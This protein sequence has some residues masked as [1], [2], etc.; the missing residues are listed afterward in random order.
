M[1]DLVQ[2]ENVTARLVARDWAW[3][4]ANRDRIAANWCRRLAATPA[5]FNGRVLMISRL[6]VDADR[7]AVDFFA[8]DYATLL[9]H[10]DFGFEDASVHNGF[11]MGALS[12]RDG[13]F[14]LAEMS[15]GTANAGRLYFAAGTPDRSDVR[16]DDSVD[17]A[18]SILREIGEET[19]LTLGSE[20]LAPGWVVVRHEGRI[21]FMRSVRLAEPADDAR[22]RILAHIAADPKAE[23]ADVVVLRSIA[24]IERESPR[25]PTFLPTYLRWALTEGAAQR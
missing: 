2:V 22:A 23:L 11:A 12:G 25:M 6:Q 1:I 17:L 14:L 3:E 13:G 18:G 7:A 5:L 19:G 16:D 24:D 9:A 20:A 15:A 8:V 4:A 10:A 21:A